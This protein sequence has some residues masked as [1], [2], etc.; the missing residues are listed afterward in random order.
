[1]TTAQQTVSQAG[2][3]IGG[4]EHTNS[5]DPL[6]VVNPADGRPFASVAAA[7]ATDVDAAVG[8]ALDAFQEWSALA[9]SKRGQILGRARTPPSAGTSSYR[10]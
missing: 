9:V 7:S 2:A 3:F 8:A 10:K 1:M 5:G 4:A 6:P